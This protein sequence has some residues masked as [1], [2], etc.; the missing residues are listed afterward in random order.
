MPTQP[1]RRF[2]EFWGK[3][4]SENLKMLGYVKK[5]KLGKEYNYKTIAA[6]LTTPSFL[7]RISI[8][9]RVIEVAPYNKSGIKN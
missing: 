8:K 7:S 9:L 1:I 3:Y 5:M 2:N 4:P 6:R